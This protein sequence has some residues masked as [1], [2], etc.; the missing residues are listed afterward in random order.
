MR[1]VI[2]NGAKL[3]ARASC[4]H[5]GQAIRDSYIREMR[6]RLIYCDFHC[7]SVWRETSVLTRG[8]SLP[9]LG[10]GIRTS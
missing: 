2:V 8:Y 10:A 5:C 3:K 1:C 4:A 6:S 9:A 7:Y